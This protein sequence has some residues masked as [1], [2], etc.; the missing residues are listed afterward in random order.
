MAET[1][2]QV[3]QAVLVIVSDLS[4]V[5]G[6]L[7]CQDHL[8]QVTSVFLGE[9]GDE[10]RCGDLGRGQNVLCDASTVARRDANNHR[11]TWR[12]RSGGSGRRNHGS[13]CRIGQDHS[14]IG[15]RHER[16][17]PELGNIHGVEQ[18]FLS[19]NNDQSGQSGDLLGGNRFATVDGLE[20]C[21]DSGRK[22]I[23]RR[24]WRLGAVSRRAS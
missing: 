17:A 21:L 15:R 5:A 20:S 23:C 12:T 7:V 22:A 9:L 3:S 16:L 11:R 19:V 24:R 2:H 4:P 8:G 10:L 18:P 13:G 6:S 1:A 14:Q